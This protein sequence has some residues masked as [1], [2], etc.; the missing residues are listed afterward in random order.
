MLFKSKAIDSYDNL[1][2][3]TMNTSRANLALSIAV[4]VL[5]IMLAMKS[6]IAVVT[7]SNFSEPITMEAGKIAN[8]EF[9]IQWAISIATLLGNVNKKNYQFVIDRITN[10][11]PPEL[12]P[13][14]AE[15][16]ILAMLEENE[17]RG[18]RQEFTLTDAAYSTA[19][20]YVWIFG[21]KKTTSIRSGATDSSPWTFELRIGARN[22]S[23]KI[24]DIQQ[25]PELLIPSKRER[26]IAIGMTQNPNMVLEGSEIIKYTEPKGANQ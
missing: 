20:D 1:D 3:A 6:E 7:P 16:S 13:A 24:L 4:V 8:K 19:V 2:K 9:K 17:L 26:E 14:K 22:G 12:N 23:P 10:L 18:V 21:E 25:Y 15:A 11:I 5:I